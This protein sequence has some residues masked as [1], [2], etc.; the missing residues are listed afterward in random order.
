MATGKRTVK[1]MCDDKVFNS[2]ALR[3]LDARGTIL[4]PKGDGRIEIPQGL[5]RLMGWRNKSIVRIGTCLRGLSLASDDFPVPEP[6]GQVAVSMDRVRIPV[7][8]LRKAGINGKPG[9]TVTP[10]LNKPMLIVLPYML[11]RVGSVATVLSEMGEATCAKLLAAIDGKTVSARLRE[12]DAVP[13]LVP[14][15]EPL[16]SGTEPKLFFPSP[17][18]PTVIR[19]I[20][21]PFMFQAHW[22]A[23]VGGGTF[24]VHKVECP[25]CKE[26]GPERLYLVPV[27]R[28]GAELEQAGFLLAKEELR[29]VIG[30]VLSGSNP[31]AFDLMLYY[32]PFAYGMF[33][34]FRKPPEP[35][36]DGLVESAQ[37]MC[38]DPDAFLESVFAEPDADA[39]AQRSP[40]V[41]VK[42]H[43]GSSFVPRNFGE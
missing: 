22:V 10:D 7:S 13:E 9:V 35:L 37:E 34:V 1:R 41:M 4:Y 5:V 25:L 17:F 11:D 16:D 15:T 14:G 19:V 3:L 27:I 18:K 33:E 21:Q 23:T 26:R 2:L 6:L 32:K 42:S 24:I 28:R 38:G 43:F 29:A 20:G 40:A 30:R 39:V 12:A 36:V 31:S 8:I